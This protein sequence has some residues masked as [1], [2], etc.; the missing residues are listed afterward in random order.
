M[1]ILS[2]VSKNQKNVR[3]PNHHYF[4][5]KHC[6]TPPICIAI[7]LQ[8]VSQYFGENLGGC[9]HRDV[10]PQKKL[11]CKHEASNCTVR[12]KIISGSLVIL[13]NFFP[14][15]YRYCLE[16]QTNSSGVA[17]ANQTKER[18][19]NETFMNFAHFCEF[20][21]FCLGKQARF[22]LNFCSGM[23]R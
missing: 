7:R 18:A 3:N 10:P 1:L 12:V 16:I 8:F 11:D 15:N 21:C 2:T 23:P 13:E 9:G 6:N 17:P 4:S 14:H 19:K 22:T 20:W 5:E